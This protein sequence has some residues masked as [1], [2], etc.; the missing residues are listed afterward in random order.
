MRIYKYPAKLG[1]F[2]IQMPG[3][4][5]VL[6]LGK[7]TLGRDEDLTPNFSIWA[8]VEDRATLPIEW[9]EFYLGATGENLPDWADRRAYV[10]TAKC[11]WFVAHLFQN[12]A[13]YLPEGP[14]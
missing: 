7:D 6:H 14:K 13:R 5:E 12:D 8:L 3:G 10:N 4:A 9:R 11:Y 2:R 1:I